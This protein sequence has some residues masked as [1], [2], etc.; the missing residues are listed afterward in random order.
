MFVYFNYNPLQKHVR[1][2]VYRAMAYFFGKSWRD[3]VQMVVDFNCEKGLVNFTHIS[4]I[5]DFMKSKGFERHKTPRKG[6]KVSEFVDKYAKE[7]Y[8]YMLY[9]IRPLHLTI[10]DENKDINDTWDCSDRE[11]KYYWFRTLV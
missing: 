8:I 7:G 6:M 1:D 2:G 11:M 3:A 5:T 10:I 9:T 4:N